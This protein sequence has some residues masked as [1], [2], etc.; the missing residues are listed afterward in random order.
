ML[1]NEEARRS[2]LDV[3]GKRNS[4]EVRNE[5]LVIFGTRTVI[6]QRMFLIEEN[7]HQGFGLGH[8][9]TRRNFFDDI[10]SRV[11]AFRRRWEMASGRRERSF[12][13][14]VARAR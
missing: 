9:M 3:V 10:T 4:C 1:T 7:W 11:G 12:E 6:S 2:V 5:L 14:A 8:R 13:N